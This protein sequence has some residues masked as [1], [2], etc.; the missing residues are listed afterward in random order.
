MN[1][2]KK[3]IKYKIKYLNLQNQIGGAQ[4]ASDTNTQAPVGTPASE[5]TA[6]VDVPADAPAAAAAADATAQAIFADIKVT[7]R[8]ILERMQQRKAEAK[9]DKDL[10]ELITSLLAKPNM[11]HFMSFLK[12]QNNKTN[13]DILDPFTDKIKKLVQKLALIISNENKNTKFWKLFNIFK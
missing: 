5:I 9:K 8:N 12:A 6:S 7:F 3:Y 13:P 4:A 1:Y 2:K 10:F 11:D